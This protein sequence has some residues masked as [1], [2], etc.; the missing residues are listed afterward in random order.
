MLL[1]FV[2]DDVTLIKQLKSIILLVS[3]N[4]CIID[5]ELY[6]YSVSLVYWIEQALDM[7]KIYE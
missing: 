2:W 1:C 5:T 7:Q 6:A 3:R 4:L